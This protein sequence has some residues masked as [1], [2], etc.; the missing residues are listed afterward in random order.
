MTIVRKLFSRLQRRAAF[1][2]LMFTSD[3]DGRPLPTALA[4]CIS[5]ANRARFFRLNS[6]NSPFD[7]EWRIAV[8]GA[9]IVN[10]DAARDQLEMMFSEKPPS[11]EL[12]KRI[13]NLKH[14]DF[15]SN[16]RNLEV[17][18][19]QIPPINGRV[20]IGPLRVTT[21]PKGRFF[22]WL[23]SNRPRWVAPKSKITGLG[24]SV[25]IWIKDG[26]VDAYDW[27]VSKR[28]AVTD[29]LDVF[30]TELATVGREYASEIGFR[31]KDD[32]E[33]EQK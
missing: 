31:L 32:P 4:S 25:A 12:G 7:P 2:P 13:A 21:E 20:V 5:Y 29:A 17:H 15:I 18:G 11:E 22:F 9:A 19:R 27:T 10:A 14:K 33:F 30:L 26:R 6:I 1:K 3:R 24:R 16:L 8:L 28:I 23:A